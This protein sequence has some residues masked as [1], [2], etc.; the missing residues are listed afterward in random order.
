MISMK[1]YKNIESASKSRND[2][3]VLK[4]NVKAE[5]FPIEILDFPNLTELFL[6]GSCKKFPVITPGWEKLKVL[7]I[8][9]P[10]FD[11]DLSAI[12]KLP[13]LENLK[14]IETPLNTFILPLGHSS[15]P[16]KSLSIKNCHL[17]LLP[18]EF[19]I[20]NNLYELNLSGNNLSRL[21][22]SFIELTNLKR[23]NLDYNKFSHFPD[24]IK[25]MKHLS[26]LSIDHNLFSQD[27][28]DRIQRE[29]HITPS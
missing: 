3:E 13:Q 7:S 25:K 29:F 19:S 10:N 18:E 17:N 16:I 1:L 8:K 4:I 15:A 27:E 2:V 28:K 9:W 12:F 21:P 24:F 26:H 11:G 5:D 20:L 23:L 22:S 6:E 14:I